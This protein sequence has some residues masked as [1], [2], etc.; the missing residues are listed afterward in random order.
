MNKVTVQANQN[1]VDIC[2]QEYGTLDMLFELHEDNGLMEF[3][4]E[5]HTGLMLVVSPDKKTDNRAVSILTMDPPATG[6]V[7]IHE[8]I[9]FWAIE[10][11]FKVN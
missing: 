4:A 2:L 9:E 6:H 8:G 1:I 5:V 10:Y 3:P 7:I 11:D